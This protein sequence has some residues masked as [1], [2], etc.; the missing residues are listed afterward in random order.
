MFEERLI[1]LAV[2]KAKHGHCNVP[3]TPSSNH[4]ALGKRC[5]SMRVSYKQIQEGKTPHRSIS[6]DH[7]GRL[8]ALG[9]E[10]VRNTNQLSFE[11]SFIEL[12]VYK[13]NHGTCN[14]STTRASEYKSLGQWCSRSSLKQIQEGKTP[15]R[16]LSQDLM[17]RFRALHFEWEQEVT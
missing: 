13:A 15:R 6:H 12:A 8:E 10:W 9:L 7:I 16:P 14:A 11:E 1:E 17:G 5:S 3:K 2:F 4:K